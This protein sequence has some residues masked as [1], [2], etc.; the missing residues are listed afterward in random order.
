MKDIVFSIDPDIIVGVGTLNRAGIVCEAIGNR[1]LIVTERNLHSNQCIERLVNILKDSSVEAIV[2]DEVPA[3]ATADIA[4]KASELANS[5]RCSL[6]IGFGG[7]KTQ[8]IARLCAILSASDNGLF[9]ILDGEHSTLNCIPY[10]GIPTS[11]RDPFIFTDYFIVVDPRDRIIKQVKA[12]RKLC[13]AVLFDGQLAESMAGS[14]AVTMAFDG[15]CCA[16]EAYCSRRANF[17]SDTLLERAIALYSQLIRNIGGNDLG[18]IAELSINAGL[19]MALGTMLSA[20]G[21][22]IALSHS[23]NGRF[24]ISKSWCTTIILPSI[25]ERLITVRPEKIA[26]VAKIMEEAVA[27][28][29]VSDTAERA[30]GAIRQYMHH[31]N[32]S[33]QFKDLNLPTDKIMP[34][35]QA[36][37]SMGFVA[38][39]PWTIT[40]EAAFEIL[41]EAFC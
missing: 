4:E 18:N 20:P 30:V 36:A 1:A 34:L 35:A 28:E 6:I 13:A 31:L 40:T 9:E 5:G 26:T 10:V 32:V 11:G 15:F 38:F 29:S 27:G 8:A 3:Q 33:A 22:G 41:H 12:P 21:L 14:F 37:Q 16:V 17:I 23:V 2:F 25:M 7:L 24:P 39:S 19:S